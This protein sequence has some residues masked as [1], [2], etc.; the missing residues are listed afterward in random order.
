[1]IKNDEVK[2][3]GQAFEGAQTVLGYLLY[4]VSAA[5]YSKSGEFIS[6]GRFTRS[7]IYSL[8][9]VIVFAGYSLVQLFMFILCFTLE[10]KFFVFKPLVFSNRE[11]FELIDCLLT[12]I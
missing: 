5:V 11:W 7:F 6:V 1:M 10:L 2:K 3:L 9:L 4:F 12:L 8:L